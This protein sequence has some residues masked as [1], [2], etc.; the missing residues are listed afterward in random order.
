MVSSKPERGSSVMSRA[1]NATLLCALSLVVSL[2]W[3]GGA[4]PASPLKGYSEV[5]LEPFT[6]DVAAANAG[7]PSGYDKVIEKLTF[8]G[9]KTSALFGEV[10]QV[11]GAGA[12]SQNSPAA[13]NPRRAVVLS[14]TMIGYDPGN[15]ILRALVSLG[16]GEAKVKVRFVFR[17][18]QS[19]SQVLSAD[20]QGTYQGNWSPT[21]ASKEDATWQCLR[22]VVKSLLKEIRATQ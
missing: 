10:V 8:E 3:A 1:L 17:D 11:S 7:F 13:E 18:W 21:G 15:R 14:A 22:N 20:L 6:I 2:A 12:E 19:N 5:R 9:L 4:K 16:A